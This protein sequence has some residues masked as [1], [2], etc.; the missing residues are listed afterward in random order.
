[1]S[2]IKDIVE[3]RLQQS[4]AAIRMAEIAAA[5]IGTMC[6]TGCT[7][8]HSIRFQLILRRQ[9]MMLECIMV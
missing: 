8:P 4:E 1:M 6:V 9:M 5:Q 7:M 2:D 3:Y